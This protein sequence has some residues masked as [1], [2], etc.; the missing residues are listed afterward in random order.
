[1]KEITMTNTNRVIE[2]VEFKLNDG[3]DAETFIKAAN[4]TVEFVESLDGFIKRSLSQGEDGI[5]MDI[6]EWRDMASAKS[7]AEKFPQAE[8]AKAL[9]SMI[10]MQT[11]KM[12]HLKIRLKS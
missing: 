3:V 9:C 12:Q 5:W 6:V 7:A 1:M 2:V 4:D 11:A 10:K 8:E